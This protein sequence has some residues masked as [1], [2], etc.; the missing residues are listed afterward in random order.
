MVKNRAPRQ[1]NR[2]DLQKL[3][4]PLYTLSCLAQAFSLLTHTGLRPF[5]FWPLATNLLFF[6]TA[7]VIVSFAFISLLNSLL[8]AWLDWITFLLWPLFTLTF[9]LI[10]FGTFAI[11]ANL[12]GAPF[13]DRLAAQTEEL[14]TGQRP[15]APPRPLWEELRAEFSR[16]GYYLK[17]AVPL[18]LL[19]L[20]PPLNLIASPLWL[21]WQAWFLGL[22]Y[23]AYPLQ[24]RGM[25]FPDQLDLLRKARWGVFVFGGAVMVGLT[26]PLLN[27]LIPPVAVIAAT[28]YFSSASL[29]N[30]G[31]PPEGAS[32]QRA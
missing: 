1:R 24:N 9:F 3:N 27:I 22:E 19:S 28:I 31:K 8:P 29:T 4:S 16:W 10:T 20:V 17:W 30:A 7:F 25:L 5:L 18:A 6:A 26:V 21:L 11:A 2:Y 15:K 12:I 23:T 13:Y 32:P 14:L